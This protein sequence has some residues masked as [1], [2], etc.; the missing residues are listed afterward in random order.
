MKSLYQN[1]FAV[2]ETIED[3]LEKGRAMPALVLLYSAIDAVA[4]LER[5]SG[6]DTKAYFK[7]WVEAYMLKALPPPCTAL[8]LYAA[9]CG[10]V[11]NFAAESDL[12][13]KGQVR[14]IV[15]AWG[16]AKAEDLQKAGDIL[17]RTDSV[18]VHVTDII[19]A[20]RNGLEN[21]LEEISADKLRQ[22]R[23]A[24][25]LSIWLINLQPASIEALLCMHASISKD[26]T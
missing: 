5:Q 23:V 11:H 19:K 21:Y 25:G 13:R 6:E 24:K 15:Y 17:H 26:P 8:E 7:R 4:S 9:R 22:E 18:A 10:I 2:L 16:T 14:C 12:F 3:C 20:F 1:M